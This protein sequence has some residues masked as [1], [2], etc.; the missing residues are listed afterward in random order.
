MYGY[1]IHSGMPTMHGGL[2]GHGLSNSEIQRLSGYANTARRLATPRGVAGLFGGANCYSSMPQ[3]M[4]SLGGYLLGGRFTKGEPQDEAT[5]RKMYDARYGQGKY[6]ARIAGPV[7]VLPAQAPRARKARETQRTKLANH[8]K[9]LVDAERMGAILE[10]DAGH[11]ELAGYLDRDADYNEGVRGMDKYPA[12]LKNQFDVPKRIRAKKGDAKPRDLYYL[13]KKGKVINMK[14]GSV[15]HMKATLRGDK[16][17]S[18]E[19]SNP[20]FPM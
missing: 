12:Y 11:P 16:I 2:T 7:Q 13:T 14:E 20:Y 5:K 8:L 1:N 15:K 10:A 4:H 6:D 9:R 18:Y 3:Q 17:G 19:H